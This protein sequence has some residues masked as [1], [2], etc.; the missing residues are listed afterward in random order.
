[1]SG[2]ARI[3]PNSGVFIK[4]LLWEY[5][6]HV[7]TFI[8]APVDITPSI[9]RI[10]RQFRLIDM[11]REL[12]DHFERIFFQ[13]L[14]DL[15]EPVRGKCIR[16]VS[17]PPQ[18]LFAFVNGFSL[19]SRALIPI[20]KLRKTFKF[21][22]IHSH[23]IIPDGLAG[24]LLGKLFKCP[25]I[26]TA[27]G[28]DI[29]SI[30]K[31]SSVYKTINYVLNSTDA[32]TCVSQDLKERIANFGVTEEKIFVIPNGVSI[33][34]SKGNK[35]KNLRKQFDIPENAPFFLFVGSLRP[36]KDPLTLLLSF[37]KVLQK[38]SNAHLIMVGS[39][40]MEK[41]VYSYVK[42]LNIT[43]QIDFTGA[44]PHKEVANYMN[45][46][47]IFCLSSLQE[48]WPTV[49]FEAISFGKPIVATN[50]GGIPEAI[51]S[52]DYGF[53]VPPNQPDKMAVAMLEAA[54]KK[55]NHNK[56]RNYAH[57]NTWDKVAKK[58]FD[59]YEKVLCN[60]KSDM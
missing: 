52:E 59:V 12:K 6:K 20:Y 10:I 46:C 37:K 25:T 51:C 9:R 11:F 32:I 18:S 15:E 60:Q 35:I 36:I 28:S 5:K 8:Y 55:W 50:V 57:N 47:D 58:Y 34:F 45:S 41:E 27:H 54:Q 44:I 4:S 24:A 40:E 42:K 43:R 7:N 48:G 26:V 31:S 16:F 13:K 19:F 39:G 17:I 3:N 14:P 2:Q 1:M 22:I 33:Q 29:H 23:T 56:I 30:K 21:N 49:L 38:K 53:L